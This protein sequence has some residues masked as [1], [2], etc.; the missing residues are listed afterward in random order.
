LILRPFPL[1]AILQ[2]GL[3]GL[4][5]FGAIPV[6]LEAGHAVGLSLPAWY[7]EARFIRPAVDPLL[8][9]TIP[10]F[11]HTSSF[12]IDPERTATLR[13]GRALCPEG[14]S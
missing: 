4:I 6:E 8:K 3:V 11:L 1:P 2:P 7:P 13:D 9:E 10:G 12:S 14:D 5:A